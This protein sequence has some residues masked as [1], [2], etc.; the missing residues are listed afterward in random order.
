MFV[1][2]FLP[3]K[4]AYIWSGPTTTDARCVGS[5]SASYAEVNINCG[6]Y[7]PSGM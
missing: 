6:E 4:S 1:G 5:M 7:V 3:C 2:S